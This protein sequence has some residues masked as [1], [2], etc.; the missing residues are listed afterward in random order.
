[1]IAPSITTPELAYFQRA[2]SSLRASATIIGVFKRPA[3][4]IDRLVFP[5]SLCEKQSLYAIYVKNALC[6]QSFPLPPNPS[7]VVL[8]GCKKL[9]NGTC[10]RLAAFPCN[11]SADQ[12]FTIDT[13]SLR[14]A[15]TARHCNRRCLY[16]VALYP[17]FLARHAPQPEAIQPGIL[18]HAIG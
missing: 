6:N 12:R 15:M 1:M 17:S 8:L 3:F 14:S 2:T 4:P 11:Q 18:N 16:D 10:T 9:D 7:V 5:D 13:V